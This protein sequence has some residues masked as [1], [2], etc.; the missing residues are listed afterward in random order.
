M[1][2][3]CAI[4][5]LIGNFIKANKMKEL[6]KDIEG[7]KGIY[8]V[9]NK[10]RVRSIKR[11]VNTLKSYKTKE[12][13]I[14]KQ[15]ISNNYFQVGLQGK[16]FSVHRLV[17]QAF[18]DNPYRKPQVNH[19][20]ENKLDNNV[21]NLEWCTAKENV[22]YGTCIERRAKKQRETKC[23]INNKATSKKIRCLETGKVF[24]SINDAGRIMGLDNSSISKVCKGK[25][26]QTKGFTFRYEQ[27]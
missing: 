9:S 11:I 16:R 17:A 24:E 1:P 26:K 12:E 15:S 8:Q 27:L 20:N 2:I 14:L 25:I 23:Q 22:N 21:E 4:I 5:F 19:K 3:A 7:Y 13:K 6:W 10:G 18:I